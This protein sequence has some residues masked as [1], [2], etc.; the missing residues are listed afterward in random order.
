ML[1]LLQFDT[2]RI[3]IVTS[4]KQILCLFY[5]HLNRFLLL[6]LRHPRMLKSG[7]IRLCEKFRWTFWSSK[8]DMSNLFFD[9]AWQKGNVLRFVKSYS[10]MWIQIC[11]INHSGD[12]WWST[13]V[14]GIFFNPWRRSSGCR[15]SQS[16]GFVRCL[17][18]IGKLMFFKF[19]NVQLKLW[20]WYI[21]PR[22]R[23]LPFLVVRFFHRLLEIFIL[24]L[25]PLL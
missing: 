9:S 10:P 7:W 6:L 20:Q 12:F 22:L 23:L 15:W 5:S 3:L 2:L 13:C 24:N 11:L 21:L 19:W 1:R 14:A 17:F 8:R 4:F 18:T 25:E 16:W